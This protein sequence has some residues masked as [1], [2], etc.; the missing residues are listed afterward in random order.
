MEVDL[1]NAVLIFDEAHNVESISEDG[2][3]FSF[4]LKDLESCERDFKLL[5]QKLKEKNEECKISE[6]D[7]RKLEYPIIS[8][9]N[10]MSEMKK[11]FETEFKSI[12]K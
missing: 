6:Q 10:N 1:E 2:S 11:E 7:I 3:S 8:L 5:R 4:S 12:T 9:Y